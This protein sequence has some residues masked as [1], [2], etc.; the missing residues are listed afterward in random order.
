MV[1]TELLR[2]YPFF[3]F[4]NADQLK[5]IAMLSEEVE[6]KKGERIFEECGEADALYL[7]MDGSVELYYRSQEEFHPKA[8]KEFHIGDINPGEIFAVSSLIEPYALNNTAV[9]A[10]DCHAIKIEAA[11]LR[12]LIENDPILGYRLMYQVTK[13]LMERLADVRAQLAA[14]WS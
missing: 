1:S 2:R 12:Q 6:F 14:A 3:G 11:G 4:L 5:S 13:A 9:A 10:Q 8:R 7:L